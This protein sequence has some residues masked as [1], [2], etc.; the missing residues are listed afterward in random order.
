MQ[1]GYVKNYTDAISVT[2]QSLVR[3]GDG[4][5]NGGRGLT[6]AAFPLEVFAK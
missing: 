5:R 2:E 6:V 4:W 3:I 1:A